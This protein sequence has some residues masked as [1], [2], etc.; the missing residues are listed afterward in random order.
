MKKLKYN[1]DHIFSTANKLVVTIDQTGTKA[2]IREQGQSEAT[3]RQGYRVR[4]DGETIATGDWHQSE[5]EV[6]LETI[7]RERYAHLAYKELYYDLVNKL[8]SIGFYEA[9]EDDD[10]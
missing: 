5:Y 1:K 8:A 3:L 6:L 2:W 9:D 10:N 7:K 4:V